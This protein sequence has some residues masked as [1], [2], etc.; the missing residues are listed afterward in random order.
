MQTRLLLESLLM[1]SDPNNATNTTAPSP[2]PIP[3]TAHPTTYSFN[4]P[5]EGVTTVPNERDGEDDAGVDGMR[6]SGQRR[7]A[8]EEY[9]T[10]PRQ[11]LTSQPKL[12]QA[13]LLDADFIAPNVCSRC[14]HTC[15]DWRRWCCV[16]CSILQQAQLL[17]GPR[18]E[19]ETPADDADNGHHQLDLVVDGSLE[20]DTLC[21]GWGQPKG[22]SPV[23][24]AMF[25]EKKGHDTRLRTCG[26]E[27]SPRGALA[28]MIV[29]D[30][31][32]GGLPCAP[33]GYMGLG[34]MFCG[35]QT[36][37]LVRKRYRLKGFGAADCC[38]NMLCPQCAIEQQY[39]ELQRQGLA[40]PPSPWTM[41]L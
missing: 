15:F 25:T 36:R 38:I 27:W 7:T 11:L 33:C 26:C 2:R 20:P 18:H 40:E 37:W 35:V 23:D 19:K 34:T 39:R 4:H 12:V 14:K 22:P 1:H 17:I 16:R 24:A 10:R 41:D 3:P 13:V 9:F 5:S 21:C 30:V 29:A 8:R 32:S 31:L 6:G 28:A